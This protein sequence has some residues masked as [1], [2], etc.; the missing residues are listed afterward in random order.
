MTKFTATA[1]LTLLLSGCSGQMIFLL[2]EED[3]P[4]ANK[5]K[6]VQITWIT[7]SNPNERCSRMANAKPSA[8]KRFV[9]CAAYDESANTCTIVTSP[10]T[11]NEV[12]GHEMRHCFEGQFHD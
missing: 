8:T 4:V 9:G 2:P 7:D 1:L 11:T 3:F 6:M 10:T 5:S 12:I